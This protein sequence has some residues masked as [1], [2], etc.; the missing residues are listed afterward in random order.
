MGLNGALKLVKLSRSTWYDQFKLKPDKYRQIKRDLRQTVIDNAPYGYRRVHS[1]LTD[2]DDGYGHQVSQD[3]VRLLMKDMAIQVANRPSKPK[4]GPVQRIINEAGDEIN[5]VT[6]LEEKREVKIGEVGVT[7]FTEIVYD[8]G[9]KKVQLMTVL[10]YRG[11]VVL[12]WEAADHKDT[13]LALRVW[14]KTKYNLSRLKLSVKKFIIHS[15]QDS[16]LT[17]LV[18]V[19]Q[20]LV[21]DEALVS[22]STN[23]CHGN[24]RMESWHSRFK[25]ENK[26]LFADCKTLEEVRRK[27]KRQVSYYNYRRR[28]SALKNKAPMKYI[29]IR[30]N[31]LV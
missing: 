30:L 29:K 26:G 17:G 27:I 23:G 24:T 4:P 6:K 7:D 10:D 19:R 9:T 20:V 22:Y 31:L 15:D 25:G 3:K 28:H 16:V 12:G 21:D 18:W 8:N 2:Q 11:R 14:R 1:E 5:L 13:Q